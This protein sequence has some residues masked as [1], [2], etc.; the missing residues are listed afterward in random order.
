MI[1]TAEAD[2]GSDA[3]TAIPG[4]QDVVAG[5]QPEIATTTT[6]SA[7]GPQGGVNG[8]VGEDPNGGVVVSTTATTTVDPVTGEPVTTTPETVTTT[9]PRHRPGD[10]R[11]GR[12]RATVDRARP[13]G[14]TVTTGADGDSR[15]P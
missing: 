13:T 14:T 1:S 11:H 4:D 8:V 15:R 3:A 9:R 6:A 5:A 12:R 2:A 7:T 10:R